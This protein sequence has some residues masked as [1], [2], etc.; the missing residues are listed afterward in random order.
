[1]SVQGIP[2]DAVDFFDDLAGENTREWW[3]ANK[4]R[5]TASVREPMERLLDA[6]EEEFGPAHLFRPNRDVRF[7]ADKSP[8]KDHQGALVG[9]V[10]GMGWYVQVGADGLT[11][12]AGYYPTGPD[13]LARL[14]AAVD[15]PASGTALQRVVDDLRAAGFEVRGDRVA[16]RPRGVPADHPRLELLRHRSM[17]V[18]REHGEPDWLSTPAVVERVRADWRSTRPFVEWLT[19]HV[20]ASREPRRR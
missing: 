17:V 3:L 9:T 14:R 8:Y 7:S 20:G 10:G 6:L 5:W 16:T 1:V 4:A 18:V 15:A 2:T 11:T 13:Q 12:G 19:E